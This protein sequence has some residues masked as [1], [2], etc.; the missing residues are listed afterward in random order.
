MEA[1][2]VCDLSKEDQVDLTFDCIPAEDLYPQGFFAMMWASYMN[3][4]VDRRIHFWGTENDRTSWTTFGEGEGQE[5]EV[6]TVSYSGIP[7]LP[8]EEGAQTLNLIENPEKKFLTPFYYG[9]L[10]GDHNLETIED[11]VLYMVL[12]DQT[13]PIR[14][15]MWNFFNDENGDPDTH[16]PAWDWQFV[17]RDP[18]VGQQYRYRARVVVKPFEGEE[19]VWREYRRWGKDLGVDL[20]QMEE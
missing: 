2:M 8:Y 3:R 15:A 17:I 12:F 7:D 11:K 20:P 13:D 10:D 6:G 14:F 5:I 18:Q 4:A 1:R 16:S 9:L 19:Q